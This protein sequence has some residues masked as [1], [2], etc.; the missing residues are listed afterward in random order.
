MDNILYHLNI[1]ISNLNLVLILFDY[2]N[3][4]YITISKLKNIMISLEENLS[5]EEIDE[6]LKEADMN[7]DGKIKFSDLILKIIN[8]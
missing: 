5:E 7:G 4:G 6:M 2:Q 3:N 1:S 8:T